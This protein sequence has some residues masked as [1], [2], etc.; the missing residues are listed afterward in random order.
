M[1]RTCSTR[2]GLFWGYGGGLAAY[3]TFSSLNWY[4][5]CKKGTIAFQCSTTSA[6]EKPPQGGFSVGRERQC[7]TLPRRD[8]Q[9][10]AGTRSAEWGAKS[11]PRNF[12]RA[13]ASKNVLGQCR[14]APATSKK[15]NAP[16]GRFAL[17]PQGNGPSVC[18]A[19]ENELCE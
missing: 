2:G 5:C 12:L 4:I 14:P 8:L 11:G 3:A 17:R 15:Q 6:T 19:G 7:G 16:R 13:T 9:D 18:E 1:I 10:F